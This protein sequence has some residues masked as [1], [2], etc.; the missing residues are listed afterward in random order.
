MAELE[1]ALQRPACQCQKSISSDVMAGPLCVASN[2][3]AYYMAV[4]KEI[5][6]GFGGLKFDDK[7]SIMFHGS[8]SFF[9]LLSNNLT[10][11]LLAHGIL[12]GEKFDDEID[13]RK[14]LVANACLPAKIT[15]NLAETPVS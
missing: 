11:E 10:E 1:A 13:G 6:R 5:K 15:E 8:T 9:Q 12:P 14:L 7:G 4:P 3:Q 2:E